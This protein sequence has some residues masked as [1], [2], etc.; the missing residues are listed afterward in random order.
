MSRQG[1]SETIKLMNMDLGLRDRLVRVVYDGLLRQY[2]PRKISVHNGVA[3]KSRIKLF[4]NTDEFPQYE[5][6]L[7]SEIRTRVSE[8][9]RVCVV[10]GGLGVSTVT[11]VEATGRQGTVWTYEGS[12]SQVDVVKKTLKLNR[13]EPYVHLVHGVVGSFSDFSSEFYGSTGSATSI[14]PEELPESEVL[15][16]DCEG[17]EIEIINNMS[18][19]PSIIIVESHGFLNSPEFKVKAKLESKGYQIQNRAVEHKQKGIV[20]LTAT[21][22]SEL[23]M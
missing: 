10:G 11:A 12:E 14:S 1:Y 15:I 6:Q 23:Y 4:D 3:V 16:L 13:V 8:S 9:D 20:V 19:C 5:A 7:V 2:L 22:P 18:D 17:A 21:K